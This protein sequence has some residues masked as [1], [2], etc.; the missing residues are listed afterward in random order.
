[1]A[2]INGPSCFI[3]ANLIFDFVFTINALG[4]ISALLEKLG[5]AKVV[6]VIAIVFCI[7]PPIGSFL[8]FLGIFDYII[9][10]RKLDPYRR[11]PLK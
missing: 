8:Y 9:D 2:L 5:A 10:Y 4:F 1:M 11:K 6:K 3:N 7:L